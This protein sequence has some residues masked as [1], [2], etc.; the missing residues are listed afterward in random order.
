MGRWS[1][2][3]QLSFV[4][5]TIRHGGRQ[6]GYERQSKRNCRYLEDR[7]S[8]EVAPQAQNPMIIGNKMECLTDVFP[9]ILAQLKEGKKGQMQM[10]TATE[11]KGIEDD[12]LAQVDSN[13]VD[14]YFAFKKALADKQFLIPEMAC[15]DVYYDQLI[16]EP[17]LKKIA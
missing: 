15:A 10:F 3:V 2:R 11:S 7:V 8:E 1:W 16:K 6:C 14:L 9:E 4:G 13:V 17:K 5:R 12:V